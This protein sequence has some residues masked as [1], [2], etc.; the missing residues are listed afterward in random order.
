MDNL[1]HAWRA[2]RDFSIKLEDGCQLVEKGIEWVVTDTRSS[3]PHCLMCLITSGLMGCEKTY[4][5]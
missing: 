4:G 5:V 3:V 2:G 1:G